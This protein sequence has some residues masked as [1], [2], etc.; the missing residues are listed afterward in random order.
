MQTQNRHTQKSLGWVFTVG[1]RIVAVWLG[2]NRSGVWQ[3]FL[4]PPRFGVC[5]LQ[6]CK[7]S[8]PHGRLVKIDAQSSQL[9]WTS[10]R[11][12]ASKTVV[13]FDDV[14]EVRIGQATKTYVFIYLFF[15]SS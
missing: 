9:L 4:S 12:K 7:H 5:K 15:Y 10:S 1:R 14:R 13:N 6:F 8:K 2:A 11:K 3:S